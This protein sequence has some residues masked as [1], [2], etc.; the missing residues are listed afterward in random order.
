MIVSNEPGRTVPCRR[1]IQVDETAC[2]EIPRLNNSNMV[3]A[4]VTA[5]AMAE[6]HPRPVLVDREILIVVVMRGILDREATANM[7]DTTA[8]AEA[9]E[10]R[11]PVLIK[12]DIIH[13][14][15]RPHQCPEELEIVDHQRVLVI[16]ADEAVTTRSLSRLSARTAVSRRRM[17]PRR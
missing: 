6:D 16:R 9:M 7:L 2:T 13:P 15:R 14:L 11:L 10:C 1:P 3:A 17:D 4:A 5:L 12:E 8:E